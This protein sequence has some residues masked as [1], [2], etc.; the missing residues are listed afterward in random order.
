MSGTNSAVAKAAG[1]VFKSL[2]YGGLKGNQT[3]PRGAAPK[4]SLITRGTS[5]GQNSPD[6]P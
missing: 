5:R 6:K 3:F 1:V 4:E 2:P